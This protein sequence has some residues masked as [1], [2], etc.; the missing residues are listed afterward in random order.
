MHEDTANEEDPWTGMEMDDDE[1]GLPKEH[2]QEEE[3]TNMPGETSRKENE[4]AGGHAKAVI[5]MILQTEKK[6]NCQPFTRPR[7]RVLHS[8]HDGACLSSA[9]NLGCGR[10]ADVP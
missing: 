10:N 5:G 2:M 6:H 7:K 3:R 9:A 8:G 1:E 4:H